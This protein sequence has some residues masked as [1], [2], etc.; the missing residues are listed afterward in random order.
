MAR[1]RNGGTICEPWKPGRTGNP[2]GSSRKQRQKALLKDF[3]AQGMAADI[4]LEVAEALK[5]QIE[6]LK[7]GEAIA[8]DILL[9][10]LAGNRDAIEQIIKMEPQALQLA[11]EIDVSPK[12]AEYVPTEDENRAAAAELS[13]GDVVH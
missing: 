10:A 13:A 4:P 2:K 12:S 1:G 7:V 11:G 9:R 3:I 6:G 8:G 5:K